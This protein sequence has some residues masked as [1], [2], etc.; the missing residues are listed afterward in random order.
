M[1]S[2]K[3]KQ[4]YVDDME[5]TALRVLKFIGFAILGA[6]LVIGIGFVVKFL[7]NSLVTDIFGLKE[8]TYW[9]A[10]GL[11]VLAKIIFGFGGGGSSSSEPKEQHHRGMIASEI[12]EAMQQEFTEEY[13]QKYKDLTPE[14]DGTQTGDISSTREANQNQDALYE[15][16]WNEEG[17]E[18]FEAFIKKEDER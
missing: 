10:V 1:S 5:H 9:Q 6:G 18:Q 8:V 13:H 2:Y 4:H 12:H 14:I 16:W 3:T 15:K 11:L 7:W 17:E